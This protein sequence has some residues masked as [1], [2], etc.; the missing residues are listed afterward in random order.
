MSNQEW[1]SKKI[2]H[3]I[4]YW[5]TVYANQRESSSTVTDE[6]AIASLTDDFAVEEKD[7]AET[8]IRFAVAS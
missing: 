8:L 4:S 6:P 2:A 7:P 3:N 5:N 1:K